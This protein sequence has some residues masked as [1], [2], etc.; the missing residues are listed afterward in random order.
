[1]YVYLMNLMTHTHT[2]LAAE[3]GAKFME[4]SA[5]SGLNVQKVRIYYVTGKTL[6]EHVEMESQNSNQTKQELHRNAITDYQP[7]SF[8][9]FSS[10]V[11]W[12]L[13]HGVTGC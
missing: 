8:G 2:Q 12:N 9:R 10:H 6:K 13:L 7:Y 3:L 5:K 4:V 1:M 11:S